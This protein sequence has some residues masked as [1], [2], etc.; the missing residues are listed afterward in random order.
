MPV[1]KE[2]SEQELSLIKERAKQQSGDSFYGATQMAINPRTIIRQGLL[3]SLSAL[4][5][6]TWSRSLS[7]FDVGK[8]LWAYLSAVSPTL[9]DMDSDGDR[10]EAGS[11]D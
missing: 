1:T 3:D 10:E 2:E 8:S 7:E 11:A 4:A 9:N 6:T 5:A